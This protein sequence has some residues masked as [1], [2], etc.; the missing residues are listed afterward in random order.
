MKTLYQ[1]ISITLLV[2][3]I[4]LLALVN[5]QRPEDETFE[6]LINQNPQNPLEQNDLPNRDGNCAEDFLTF[7]KL[8]NT[9]KLNHDEWELIWQDEFENNC[10]DSS[11]WNIEDWAAQKNNELQYYS[12][13]NVRVQNG[14]LKLISKH[15][16]FKGNEYTSGAVHTKGK[17]NFLYGK[18]EMKAKLPAGQGLFPAF[19][20]MP[21]KEGVWL[22]EI[23]I[24]EMLGHLPNE[25]WMVS[26][27][28][29]H[30]GT[31]KSDFSSF[32][33]LD[34]SEDF[35]TFSIEWTQDSIIWLIDN[36]ERFRS[37]KFIPS[38]NMYLY[39]NT[40]I[41]GDWPGSQINLQYFLQIMKLIMSGFISVIKNKEAHSLYFDFF[42]CAIISCKSA[43]PIH[44]FLLN[45]L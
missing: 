19:W 9:E 25:I 38:E 29:D 42:I 37:R 24:M 27:W 33:G 1:L 12:P 3:S 21:E 11:R 6:S 26:H 22:P 36:I 17:F 40:A 5:V 10:L 34:F 45:F 43:P 31:L 35:H 13:N 7:H 28:L 18:V 14:L 32:I 20:M 41:G 16:K 8:N 39:L 4:F 15:E 23:D 2:S 30:T 44:I